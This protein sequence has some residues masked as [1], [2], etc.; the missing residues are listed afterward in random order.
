MRPLGASDTDES[1]I[2][3]IHRLARQSGFVKSGIANVNDQSYLMLALPYLPAT[4][5]SRRVMGLFAC[6][7][8]YYYAVDLAKK[9]RRELG[10]LFAV[11]HKQLEILC[12]SQKINEKALAVQ[13]GLG[14]YGKNSLVITQPYGSFVVLLGIQLPLFLNIRHSPIQLQQD[15]PCHACNLCQVA[16]PTKALHRAYHLD[17]TLC[18]QSMASN[19]LLPMHNTMPVIYGCDICQNVCPYNREASAYYYQHADE[20]EEEPWCSME[21]WEK[22][23]LAD[24]ESAVA[25][26]PLRFRWLDKRALMLNAR[27]RYLQR[28]LVGVQSKEK[29]T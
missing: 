12:N 22:G 14:F 18:L 20:L 1:L 24:I 23:T 8:N 4:I 11:P 25:K 27:L 5:A 15:H 9:L 21:L 26:S 2:E 29:K 13:A 16:C 3:S 10:I 19:G 6:H 7:D 17:R 28:T